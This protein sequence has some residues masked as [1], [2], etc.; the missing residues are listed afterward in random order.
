MGWEG[1]VAAPP[2]EV[3]EVAHARPQDLGGLRRE[4]VA[5]QVLGVL[6]ATESPFRIPAREGD[7]TVRMDIDIF[8][9]R[10]GLFNLFLL[11]IC[12]SVFLSLSLNPFF[13]L[14]FSPL[15][16]T[17]HI[18]PFLSFSFPSSTLSLS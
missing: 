4:A 12:Y 18:C 13:S 17:L 1:G 5:L 3:V 16:Y 10:K 9:Y 7:G 8:F 2:Q 14:S 11:F 6:R 15:L